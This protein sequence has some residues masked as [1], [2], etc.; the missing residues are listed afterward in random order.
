MD[1]PFSFTTQSKGSCTQSQEMLYFLICFI[2]TSF[3]VFQSRVSQTVNNYWWNGSIAARLQTQH[4]NEEQQQ[5]LSS[6]CVQSGGWQ[7][8][9]PRPNY[10]YKY[11]VCRPGID[12]HATEASGRSLRM[13]RGRKHTLIPVFGN[14]EWSLLNSFYTRC[15]QVVSHCL[16]QS[17][18]H[19]TWALKSW[20]LWT[21]WKLMAS[22]C[23]APPYPPTAAA[24][25]GV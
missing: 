12:E 4:Q 15:S 25:P 3:T 21:S 10:K 5:R 19:S 23:C 7:P 17:F 6:V 22:E 13:Q 9:P 2:F 20:P 1:F 24:R 16:L 18:L 14:R 11:R 8:T